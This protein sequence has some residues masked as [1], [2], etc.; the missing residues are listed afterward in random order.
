MPAAFEKTEI[1]AIIMHGRHIYPTAAMKRA[2]HR[3]RLTEPCR[4]G[5]FAIGLHFF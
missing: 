3:R 4:I 1:T 2:D 5:F